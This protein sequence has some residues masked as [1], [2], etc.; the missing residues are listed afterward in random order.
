MVVKRLVV[1]TLL[2]MVLA[3]AQASA[4]KRVALVIG[5]NDYTTL[6]NLNNAKKDAEGI[7]AKLR[8]LKFDVILITNAGR[9]SIS[10]A[11]ADFEKRIA[12]ADVA[13]FYFAGHG[14]EANGKNHLIPSNARI[15][16]ED[17]LRFGS[18]DSQEFLH[19]MKRAGS[20]LNI[21]ILDACRDNPLPR[22]TRSAARGLT[23]QA[24][25]SG[26][27]GTAIIYSAAPGQRAEDG[28]KG[29]HGVFTAALLK[30][31]DE[32]GLIL[33]EV[34]KK[35][36][37]L[38]AAS[39]N[40]R[41]DP[42]FYSS[43]KGDF[44][45]KPALPKS[46]L[47]ST[48][49]ADIA[50]WY[51]VKDSKDIK[52]IKTYLS[53]FPKGVFVDLARV[54]I[55]ELEQ[56]KDLTIASLTPPITSIEE[57]D[58]TYVVVK[59][60]NLREKPS[61]K[62]KKVGRVEIDTGLKVTGKV[63]GKN[64]YRVA[65]GGDIAFVFV[66]LVKAIDRTELEAW[67]RVRNKLDTKNF[68]DFLKAHPSGHFADRARRLK[69]ALEPV[70]VAIVS[71]PKRKVPSLVKPYP[72]RYTIGDT[73]KDCPECPEMVVIPA[74]PKAIAVGKFEVTQAEW[75]III[76]WNPS[77]FSGGRNPVENVR[78]VDAQDYLGILRAETGKKYRLLSEDEWE[79]AAR[80]GTKTVYQCGNDVGCLDRV[81]W[82]NENSG[83]STH[84]VGS[85]EAN[86][87]GLHD[88]HGNVWEW[89][90]SRVL[91]GGSWTTG[92]EDVGP[93][94]RNAGTYSGGGQ[95][96]AGGFRIARDLDE[97][98]LRASN[99]NQP[100]QVAVVVPPTSNTQSTKSKP[101]SAY[102]VPEWDDYAPHPQVAVV[103]PPKL[104]IP[105]PD[106]PAIGVYPK[107]YNPGD[108]FKDCPECPEMVVVP[109]GSFRMGD[110]NDDG[111]KNEKPIHRVTIPRS[112]AVG[113]YEIT[114]VEYRNVMGS[115]PSHFGGERNPVEHVNWHDVQNFVGKLSAKTNKKY[116]LLSEGEWEYAA[117]AGTTTK[118]HCGN[119]DGCL[120]NV[121]WYD[122]NSGNHSHPVGEKE[123]NA[124]GLH[125]MHGNVW[126]W[127][128]GCWN[129][130]YDGAPTTNNG[131]LGNGVC[132]TRRVVRGGS[133]VGIP[134]LV[135]SAYRGYI[136][137]DFRGSYF[138]FRIS[139]ELNERE[140]KVAD[141]LQSKQAVLVKP[142]KSAA[143]NKEYSIAVA[144]GNE[145]FSRRQY[146]EAYK[147]FWKSAL[148][149]NEVAQV[150]LGQMLFKGQGVAKNYPKA[151]SWFRSAA[152]QGN[153]TGQH[154]LGYMYFNGYGL[155]KN[156]NEAF[157]WFSKAAA[158]GN[159]A[160]QTYLGIIYLGEGNWID[161][162]KA[163]NLFQKAAKHNFPAAQHMIGYMYYNGYSVSSD[164]NEALIWFQKAAKGN[165]AAAK[166]FIGYMYEN[167][168][169]VGSNDKEAEK[170]YRK[171]AEQ[172]HA[173]AKENL[174]RL[175][176]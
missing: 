29:G 81:G 26:I 83:N 38:V 148:N 50:Y 32:T 54:K 132:G 109:A 82:Y 42:W 166:N 34:F 164:Y 123:A 25:P 59:T 100:K 53:K 86:A 116:R 19:A 135:R 176:E 125:D 49:S 77:H 96:Y 57:M 85:K 153:I 71:P 93:Y 105:I 16:V 122:G 55:R 119:D 31:L 24:I 51:S 3:V 112:F 155:D 62:S 110:L 149:G 61:A 12:K 89:V 47:V 147:S 52:A 168:E 58:E 101:Y 65:H 13:L 8:G 91:R 137:A 163:L 78:F 5:N 22:R 95:P 144:R 152:A 40:G 146:E 142:P 92:P 111:Y 117:R 10:R 145:A 121:S 128:N 143:A 75:Q 56:Q 68:V 99:S 167:G 102:V 126:E 133:W 124:F 67:K 107:S 1:L 129:Y 20:P 21:V 2:M 120:S 90:K 174:K 160:S 69:E 63:R 139:R 18:I 98:E 161:Y 97:G 157:K 131:E 165:Y 70:Q 169:G 106:K 74:I 108:T 84:P 151:V 14:I 43:I 27:K 9:Q 94:A 87:F 60:A 48:R 36:T 88:M 66:P 46:P 114:Q 73:F 162:D 23:I 30:V 7:A 156:I 115:N 41:Q 171:A 175:L 113:K 80:A 44:Y 28:P 136:T 172:G 158:N 4:A 76:G 104:E 45:F 173:Q 33:E 103:T 138:G 150:R 79:F 37:R 17:D 15:E 118:Y 6:P 39:T 72:K 159:V 134:K 130:N 35:T 140:L 141:V 127:V 170:W 64:W 154:N 11:L